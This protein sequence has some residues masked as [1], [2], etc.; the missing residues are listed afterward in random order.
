MEENIF[1]KQIE[2]DIKYLQKNN[3]KYDLNL[4]KDEYAFNYWVLT[5]LFNIDEE[6]AYDNITEYSDNGVDC[7][8][9]FEELKELYIIQNKYYNDS[10]PVNKNY[11]INDFLYRPLNTLALN[12]YKRSPKLQ[13]IFNKWKNDSEF[14]IFLYFYVTNN[15]IDI[16][17]INTFNTFKYSND[18]IDCY[19]EAKIFYLN[20]I[21]EQYFEDRKKDNKQFKCNFL[22]INDGTFLNID[23]DNYKLPN[24]TDA[25]YILTP[26]KLIYDIV[27]EANDKKY[28][29][30]E[31]NIREYLGNKGVNAKIAKT[32]ESDSD[33]ENF[34]YYNNGITIICDA[35]KKESH[36]HIKY[37]RQFKVDNPQIVNGCQTVNTIYEVLRKCRI[38]ELDKFENTFV[39]VKLL[40]L[41]KAEDSKL[42]HDIV[43]YN[44][45]Q[46]AIT[47]KNF[48]ANKDSFMNM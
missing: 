17:L 13:E 18:K 27:K 15:I 42:Y 39:M 37:K 5:K 7:F 30:F 29:L 11:V 25:K 6:C 22:S 33:R 32:L 4:E 44:N 35:V 45:S 28:L 34:F 1:K 46:T 21:K 24:L 12:N 40:V 8:V 36:N 31:E 41:N 38:D 14:K 2:E 3:S 19:I 9:Y 48:A 23:K 47:E 10:T 20:D 26:V 16:S 43:R